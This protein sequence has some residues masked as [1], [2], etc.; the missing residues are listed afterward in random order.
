MSVSYQYLRH[1]SAG[2]IDGIQMLKKRNQANKN[3]IASVMLFTDGQANRG[4]TNKIKI[5]NEMDKYIL[6]NNNNNNTI[7]F[8]DKK[9]LQKEGE[10]EDN[11]I[12]GKNEESIANNDI[13]ACSINTFGF[14]KDHNET[15]LQEI[16]ERGNGMYSFIE[17]AEY[18]SEHLRKH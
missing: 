13:F 10:N 11:D 15:L 4:I 18:I 16:A 12:E 9:Q 1:R 14:G 17:T 8:E 3:T 7:E 5:L 6:D 2:L